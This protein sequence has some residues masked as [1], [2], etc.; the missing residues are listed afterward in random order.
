[1][2]CVRMPS[3][4]RPFN[5]G[6]LIPALMHIPFH[7][8]NV[9]PASVM[10][11]IPVQEPFWIPAERLNPCK[12]FVGHQL[13]RILSQ[14][15]SGSIGTAVPAVNSPVC[16]SSTG[17]TS[18]VSPLYDMDVSAVTDQ[19]LPNPWLKTISAQ[20]RVNEVSP[21]PTMQDFS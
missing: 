4:G 12:G 10:M 9:Y 5:N 18:R 3:A 19:W 13:K 15:R 16:S 8:C 14:W 21:T 17:D 2:L 6:I 1:M 11:S 7:I 20:P